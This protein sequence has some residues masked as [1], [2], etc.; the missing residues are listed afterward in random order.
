MNHLDEITDEKCR[1]QILKQ[2]CKSKDTETDGDL[3]I[4]GMRV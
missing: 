1:K 2:V 3:V 4:D